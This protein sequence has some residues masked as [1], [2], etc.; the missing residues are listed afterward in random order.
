MEEVG[1]D[2]AIRGRRAAVDVALTRMFNERISASAMADYDEK[3]G[4]GWEIMDKDGNAIEPLMQGPGDMV[5]VLEP[6]VALCESTVLGGAPSLAEQLN[7]Q[8]TDGSAA[9]DCVPHCSERLYDV[10]I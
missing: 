8:C 2:S 4:R 1:C 10:L 9:V 5:T 3:M 7:L 6:V